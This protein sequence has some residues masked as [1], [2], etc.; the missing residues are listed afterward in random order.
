[1]TNLWICKCSEFEKIVFECNSPRSVSSISLL[2]KINHWTNLN[3]AKAFQ[4]TICLSRFKMEKASSIKL[5]SMRISGNVQK[6]S[7]RYLFLT[8]FSTWVL[9]KRLVL[10]ATPPP[11]SYVV[12][13][14]SASHNTCYLWFW[15]SDC[16]WLE[17]MWFRE[18]CEAARYIHVM[19]G[20]CWRPIMQ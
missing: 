6:M 16:C 12:R 3:T 14:Q 5:Y 17:R 11:L 20:E 7:P 19:N 18:V 13:Y 15:W 10:K 8:Y 4:N 2:G 9:K 1:M